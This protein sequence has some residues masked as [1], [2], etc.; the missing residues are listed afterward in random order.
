MKTNSFIICILLLLLC[1]CKDDKSEEYVEP[2]A[3]NEIG[4]IIDIFELKDGSPVKIK[5][6]KQSYTLAIKEIKDYV[7][8]NC[9]LA[10]FPNGVP[11][12]LRTFVTLELKGQEVKLLE[13][14]SRKCS[15]ISYLTDGNDFDDVK[16]RIDN[17]SHSGESYYIQEF[18][19]IFGE[20]IKITD[21]SYRLFIA[22]SH[23]KLYETNEKENYKFIFI[24]TQ[25]EE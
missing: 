18:Y 25:V 11:E 20:G 21:T 5:L 7:T 6:N 8:V 2:L 14:S 19:S 9:M 13:I 23:P 24:L 22:K 17:I 3:K 10:D 1:S 16:L 15:A 4:R 12:N